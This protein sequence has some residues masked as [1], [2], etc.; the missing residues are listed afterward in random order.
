MKRLSA[1]IISL[2]FLS[3]SAKSQF[4]LE[5]KEVK[6]TAFSIPMFNVSYAYQWSASDMAERFGPNHNIGGSIMVKTKNKWIVGLKGNFLWGGEVKDQRVLRNI[7]TSDGYAIDNEGRLTDI[8]LGQR[9][10]SFFLLG[11]RL[12]NKLAPNKNSGIML[13]GGVGM[14]QHKISIKFQ[15]NIASLTDEHKKGYDRFSMGYAFNGFAGYLFMSKNR[16]ANIFL[17]FDYTHGW[18]KSL[19]KYNYDTQETDTETNTN[20][21]YGVRFGWII[22]LNRRQSQEYYY[23]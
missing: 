18:T 23:Y 17:G 22:R 13:Y 9:G 14:L 5:K 8:H 3:L 10:S 16:L 12:I 6:D 19:R 15:D 11:G 7:I 2:L 1:I 4:V 20:I 21:L